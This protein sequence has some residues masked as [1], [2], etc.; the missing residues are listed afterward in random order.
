MGCIGTGWQ[1]TTNLQGFLNEADAQV[2]AICD[3]DKNHLENA[4]RLV[5]EKYG[6]SDC[7]TYHDFRELLARDDIDAVSCG[8]PDHWHSIPAIEAAEAGKDIY[9]EKPLSHSLREGRA[10][11][12]A[13][14]KYERIWQTGSWQ[15]SVQNFWF[16]CMLVRNG[17]IG[18]VR[19][20]EVG[21]PGGHTDF[22]GTK[23][24]DEI[25]PPP[26]ELDYDRWLGPAPYFPY[27][28]SRVHKN[29]R[30]NLA[31]GGGQI[32]DWI[33]HHG[34]IAHWGLGLD[35]ESPVEVEGKG[36]YPKTGVWNTAT[37]Y[38]VVCKYANGIEM[39]LGGGVGLR[40][41]TKWIGEQ[42][43]VW[44]DRERIEAEPAA[45][46]KETF[47]PNDVQL[48]RSPGHYR[49]FLDCVKTRRQTITPCEVAHH[50]VI[51]GHL[52]QVSMLVG[53][54]IKFDPETETIINDPTANEMLSRSMRSPW[55]L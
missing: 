31:T 20:V 12:E 49:N 45:L 47:G 19:R 2:V 34:D 52:G 39:L 46:L 22:A 6:N 3:V 29:W 24:Q 43:W 48:Y 13:V 23:G 54:K 37:K 33:G 15:R 11:C 28:T 9:S 8:L 40:F 14:K 5:N 16:A 7:V 51:P 27:V 10:M 17:R 35:Y 36:A 38:H 18:E 26:P 32:M 21:L 55:H 41:G 4:V 25:Q 50:S 44:V 53:R 30:W 1:G 42:G